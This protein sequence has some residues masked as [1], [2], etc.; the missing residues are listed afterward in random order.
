MSDRMDLKVVTPEQV[1][2]TTETPKI[3][4]EA[5]N[6][7]FTLLPRHIDFT[8][9]LAPGLLIYEEM[10][11]EQEQYVALDEGILVKV[12]SE[13]LVSVRNAVTDDDLGQLERLIRD[14]FRVLDEHEQASRSAMTTLEADLVRRFMELNKK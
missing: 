6:G 5:K 3:S 2:L 1:F 8:T 12:G 10:E 13:V 9:A 11:N 4:A 14:R 7:H